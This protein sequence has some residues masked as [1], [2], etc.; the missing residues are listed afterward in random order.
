MVTAR[1]LRC[2]CI[3]ER[4]F[5]FVRTACPPS[6]VHLDRTLG[7]PIKCVAALKLK[8]DFNCISSYSR[9]ACL[10]QWQLSTHC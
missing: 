4:S 7:F 2:N 10:T 8:D 1:K 6:Y 9:G 3:V 5:G